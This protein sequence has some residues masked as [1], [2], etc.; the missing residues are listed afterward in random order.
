MNTDQ[1]IPETETVAGDRLQGVFAAALTP[2]DA[3][4]APDFGRA[5]L[6]CRWLLRQGCDGLAILGT[7]GE[8]NSFSAG[9]R[10]DLLDHLVGNGVPAAVLLPGTGCAALSDTV[11]LTAHACKLGVGGCLVLPPFYY[12]GVSEE[13]L[14]ASYSEV[15]ERVGDARLRVYLYHFPQMT[16]L[17]LSIPLIERLSD[18]YPQ[19]VVGVKDSSADLANMLSVATALPEFAVFS[20]SDELLL[21]LLE[22]GGAGC[23][24]ACCNAAAPLAA[25]VYAAW[26]NGDRENAVAVQATLSEVRRIVSAYPLSAALKALFASSA[27]R[28]GWARVRPPLVALDTDARDALAEALAAVPFATA[29]WP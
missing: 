25:A 18:R 5:T 21:P 17:F 15:I 14:F 23:I 8:A 12:K 4:L 20:G 28:E 1:S 9:E 26:R 11:A 22:G 27:G 16:G 29:P 6:H 2:I 13:G 24:T 10:M 3:D 19:T 7:T